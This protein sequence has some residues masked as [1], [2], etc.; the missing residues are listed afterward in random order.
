MPNP[1]QSLMP[2][3]TRLLRDVEAL[4]ARI[5][6]LSLADIAAQV[7]QI[8]A[9]AQANGLSAVADLA[10]GLEAMLATGCNSSLLAP[11][12]TALKEAALCDQ[13]DRG[14][15]QAWSAVLRRAA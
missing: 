14:H 8:R 11:W 9:Q 2:V 12:L 3:R 7:D 10:H 13:L 4:E 6:S 5:G 1:D 15:A